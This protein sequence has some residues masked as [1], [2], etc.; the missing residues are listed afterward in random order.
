MPILTVKLTEALN[1]FV[2]TMVESGRYED[3][4]E[5]VAAALYALEREEQERVAKPEAP[6][7]GVIGSVT[8][9]P[10]DV[11]DMKSVGQWLADRG[12]VAVE[13]PK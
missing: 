13:R 12:F 6:L 1:A 5:V 11:Q 10:P 9:L 4:A 3:A 2:L 7:A 8:A